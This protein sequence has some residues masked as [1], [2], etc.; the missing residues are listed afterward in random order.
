MSWVP[1]N[2]NHVAWTESGQRT[3]YAGRGFALQ[4]IETGDYLSKDGVRPSVWR[5]R[6]IAWEIATFADDLIRHDS[7]TVVHSA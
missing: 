2:I 4:H 1:V 7:Y 6:S 5:T 3:T